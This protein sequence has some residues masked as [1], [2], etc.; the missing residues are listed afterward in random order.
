MFNEADIFVLKKVEAPV[1]EAEQ[2]D[3]IDTD[4]ELLE[5]GIN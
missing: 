3:D 5:G 4:E 1:I 2:D